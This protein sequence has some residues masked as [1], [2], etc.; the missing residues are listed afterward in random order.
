MEGRN[1]PVGNDD[2]EKAKEIANQADLSIIF[3]NA[4]S[5]EQYIN[6][7]KSVGDRY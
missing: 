3:I 2:I 1:I 4:D 6:L 7:E 5:G